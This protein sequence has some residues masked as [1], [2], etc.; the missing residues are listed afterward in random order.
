MVAY[1]FLALFIGVMGYFVY[2]Q[3]YESEDFIN[4]SYNTTQ[5]LLAE[6]VIRGDIVAADGEILAHTTVDALG[7]ETREYPYSNMFAHVVG[8]STA[9]RTG[10]ESM[11]NFNLIHS[12]A[13]SLENVAND[14][15]GEKSTGDTV[16]T[17]LDYGLQAVAY[18]ALGSYD[19]AVIVMEPETGKIRAMVSKPD[20]DPNEV[21]EQ[22]EYLTSSDNDSSVLFNRATQGLYPPGSTFK[23]FT[24]LEYIHENEDYADYSYQCNGS[25]TLDDKT[26]R[27]Y[28]NKSHGSENLE[29]S[30]AHSCNASFANIGSTL[31][32]ENFGELCNSLLFN[33]SLPTK[34]ESAT[35]SFV[36]EKGDSTKDVLET[37][38]GQGK[39]L[40]SPLHMAL[41]MSAIANDGVLMQPYVIDY[42]KNYKG[43]VVKRY[44]AQE[45][46]TLMTESDADTLSE[47]LAA[48]TEYG[49]ADDLA[50]QSYAAYGKTGSAEFSSGSSSSHAWFVG[51]A[52]RADM[53][54]IVVSILVEDSGTGSDYAVPIA[55]KIFDAYYG[56]Y[57]E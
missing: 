15:T 19:G 51:Y 22:W 48:V 55:K 47:Y 14:L 18:D 28:K 30:F 38:I 36:L 56:S 41:V 9:G 5:E 10:I 35:S 42:T 46:G 57:S 40:V 45:Y 4:N 49:T 33:T 52:H 31:D 50:G 12:S 37:S 1:S 53:P 2:F 24:L 8:Y 17:T 3:V 32:V 43:N 16:V 27:C 44:D 21:A 25:F 11:A 54:D 6:D 13:I 26:I 29:Q 20:F 39:T 34:F 7:N 23:I